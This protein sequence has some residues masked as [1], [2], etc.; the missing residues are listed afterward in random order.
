M[1][2]AAPAD[3]DVILALSIFFPPLI[4]SCSSSSV[5][6]TYNQKFQVYTRL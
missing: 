6:F 4:R 5:R 3:F 2:N 1:H